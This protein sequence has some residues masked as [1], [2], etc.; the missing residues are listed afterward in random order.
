[1]Y[2]YGERVLGVG[3]IGEERNRESVFT[4]EMEHL[5]NSKSAA[6]RREKIRVLYRRNSRE[7]T[8]PVNQ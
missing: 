8:D 6:T 4:V 3:D 5:H 7:E 1:M 2:L